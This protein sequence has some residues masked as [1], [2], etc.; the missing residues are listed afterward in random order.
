MFYLGI[1]QHRKQLTICLRDEGGKAVWRRQVSTEP[2]RVR[3]FLHQLVNHCIEAGGYVAVVEV[4]GFNDWLLKLLPEYGCKEVVLVQ[5]EERDRRKTDRRDAYRLSE[6]LWIN[7]ARLLAGQHVH[8]LRR[9]FI[10]STEDLHDRQLTQ[11]RKRLGAS[12]TRLINRVKHA[13]L[14][15]NLQHG[16]P[17]KNIRAQGARTWLRKLTLP[18]ID[19]LEVDQALAQWDLIDE[20]IEAAE[21]QIAER[22]EKNAN[23]RWIATLYGTT[24]GY[25]ALALAASIGPIERFP[26]PR[27]LANYWGLTPGCRNS[28]EATQRLGSI[29]KQGSKTA[30]FLLCQLTLHV[31]RRDA[32]MREWYKRIK[33][34]RGSEIA[35]VAVMRRLATIIWQMLSWQQPYVSGDPGYWRSAGGSTRK[36][37]QGAA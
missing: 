27:S 33:R 26:R 14:K 29:T 24:P 31:L 18:T 21:E 16:C 7:R 11:L 10:P 25:A 4:C 19:R 35:R 15:H 32:W 3:E 28:G 22:A 17:T 13:L 12:R 34:R 8:G 20:Q 36:R 23:A 30:R 37:R 6:L 9:V 1:D 5:P 2:Q